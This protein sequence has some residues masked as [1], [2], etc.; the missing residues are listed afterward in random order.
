MEPHGQS[1]CLPQQAWYPSNVHVGRHPDH[2]MA[3]GSSL[4]KGRD[5][6]ARKSSP[7]LCEADGKNSFSVGLNIQ[8]TELYVKQERP[9]T[10][11]ISTALLNILLIL[12]KMSFNYLLTGAMLRRPA[13]L[14][15][16]VPLR[17]ELADC[18]HLDQLGNPFA[19]SR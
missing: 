5:L 16:S 11:S 7:I 15:A 1:P 19:N 18:V 14:P 3:N 8:K 4:S 13:K 12:Q 2:T 10:I 6:P 9:Q 17:K